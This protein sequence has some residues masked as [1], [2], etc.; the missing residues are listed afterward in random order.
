[1]HLPESKLFTQTANIGAVQMPSLPGLEDHDPSPNP[2]SGIKRAG[3]AKR[4]QN[5]LKFNAKKNSPVG[6]EPGAQAGT[7]MGSM[8]PEKF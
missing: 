2:F 3:Q 5:F 8:K 4:E 6:G 1:M 7:L